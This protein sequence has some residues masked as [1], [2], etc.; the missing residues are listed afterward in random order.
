MTALDDHPYLTSL[1]FKHKYEK[2]DYTCT[3]AFAKFLAP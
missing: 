2:V 1:S 3:N